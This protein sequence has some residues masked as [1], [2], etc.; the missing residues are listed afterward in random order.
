M[1]MFHFSL[2]MPQLSCVSRAL[3]AFQSLF[4]HIPN[5]AAFGSQSVAILKQLELLED[6]SSTSSRSSSSSS[7]EDFSHLIV[8]DRDADFLSVL[9]S[10][11]TYEALLDEVFGIKLGIV[12]LTK[13]SD[14]AAQQQVRNS[15]SVSTISNCFYL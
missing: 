13:E 7:T 11:V 2:E 1:L 4:G 6:S 9:L 12:D 5:R 3:V 8:L 10:P 14:A 15:R